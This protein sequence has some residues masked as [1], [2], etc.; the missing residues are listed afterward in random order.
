MLLEIVLDTTG[1]IYHNS[2]AFNR[3][4]VGFELVDRN[5]IERCDTAEH[6][7]VDVITAA[8]QRETFLHCVLCGE[9][10]LHKIVRVVL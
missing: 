7:D 3:K 8:L 1:Q 9:S 4:K 2:I 5:L 10:G 6:V